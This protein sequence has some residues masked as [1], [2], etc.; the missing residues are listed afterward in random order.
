MKLPVVSSA[1]HKGKSLHLD[2]N[3]EIITLI[4]T[5]GE[6]LGTLAWDF[7][8]DHILAYR[9]SNQADDGRIEPRISLSIR[10]KYNTPQGL[11]ME[12]RAGGIGG[13]GLFIESEAP[14]P[15]GTKLVI[16]FSLPDSP[17]EWLS[18]KGVVAWVCP[19]AD[20]YTFS[21]GMGVRFT[22]IT[23]ETRNRVLNLV[24][25]IRTANQTGSQA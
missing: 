18:A 13:G 19:K 24:R 8:I 3:R 6:T 10:V 11:H 23:T 22:D 17:T 1:R 4:G 20:Q 15:V 14:L 9:K 21:P 5:N 2:S 25:S 12:S 7:I 16:D